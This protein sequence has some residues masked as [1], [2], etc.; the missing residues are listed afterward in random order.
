MSFVCAEIMQL[1]EENC[2]FSLNFITISCLFIGRFS[3]CTFTDDDGKMYDLSSLTLFDDNYELTSSNSTRF[4]LSVC[5]SLVHKRGS[6]ICTLLLFFVFLTFF[7]CKH[8]FDK[9]GL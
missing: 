4:A 7:M 2:A 8:R 6:S 1:V 3:T 9:R 5:A